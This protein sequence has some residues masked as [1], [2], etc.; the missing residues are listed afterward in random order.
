MHPITKNIILKLS[1]FIGDCG[2]SSD[3]GPI[4]TAYIDPII[5][6]IIQYIVCDLNFLNKY[7]TLLI[8]SKTPINI[9]LPK[10]TTP[11]KYSKFNFSI[12]FIALRIGV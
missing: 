9:P 2:T 6:P 8:V 10:I 11:G 4:I 5:R 12:P 7:L 3:N 1:K